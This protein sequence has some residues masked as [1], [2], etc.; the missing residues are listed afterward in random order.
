MSA[1]GALARSG[2]PPLGPHWSGAKVVVPRPL[3]ALPVPVVPPARVVHPEPVAPVALIDVA[4]PAPVAPVAPLAPVAPVVHP[5]P[6]AR[7][8]HP[9][10][11]APTVSSATLSPAIPAAPSLTAKLLDVAVSARPGGTRRDGQVRMADAVTRAF[12]TGEHLVVQAGTGTGK[13]LAYLVPSILVALSR[14]RR[15]PVTDTPPWP[16]VARQPRSPAH[17]PVVIS[18]ANKALQSQLV[19]RDLPALVD[20]LAE[21]LNWRPAF[22]LLKGRNNYLCN[23]KLVRSGPEAEKRKRYLLDRDMWESGIRTGDRDDLTTAVPNHVWNEFSISARECPGAANCK[24]GNDCYSE[25]ARAKAGRADIVVTNHAMLAIDAATDASAL[26]EHALLV[27]DE[28]HDLFEQ[29]T[30]SLTSDLSPSSLS[31]TVLLLKQLLDET[32]HGPFQLAVDNFSAALHAITGKKS[33]LIDNLAVEQPIQLAAL[34]RECVSLGEIATLALEVIST[35]SYTVRAD[36]AVRFRAIAALTGVDDTA[37]RMVRTFNSLTDSTDAVWVHREKNAPQVLRVAPLS[38]AKTLRAGLFSRGK[39][40]V[41]TSAT[42]ML[43][44]SFDAM[45]RKW[46]LDGSTPWNKLDV[47]SPFDYR[48]SGHLYLAGHLDAPLKNIETDADLHRDMAPRLAEMAQLIEAAGGR[49]LALFASKRA[50]EWAVTVMRKRFG[51]A[52][53]LSQGDGDLDYLIRQFAEDPAVSL[54]GVASLW[55]G[56]DVPGP[57]LSL[58]IIDK[59]PFPRPD[60]PLLVARKNAIERRKKAVESFGVDWFTQLSSDPAAVQLAQGVGRLKRRDSDRGVVAILDSRLV[61]TE[62]YRDYLQSALPDYEKTGNRDMVLN[63]LRDI[64]DGN[65][66]QP[67]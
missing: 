16:A 17:G 31:A 53:I 32:V 39:T 43:G 30:S 2:P 66:A 34:R 41:L 22:A 19:R 56:V 24:S 28:A 67:R 59:I 35:D 21:T 12:E 38:V 36:P 5:A 15:A 63:Y 44:N 65:A 62:S 33:T 7:V 27:V 25:R 3:V 54:F 50:Q 6:V 37:G 13:S 51:A 52:R 14:R 40:T 20:A 45:A 29:I 61:N 18:T 46:G 26:P 57:S 9:A 23:D 47:G 1:D 58:V 55:Q 42:L 8:V 49:T 10:P 48:R 11:V 64:R 4:Y 60:D